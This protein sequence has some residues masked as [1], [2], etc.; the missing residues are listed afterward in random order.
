MEGA[1]ELQGLAKVAVSVLAGESELSKHR[2]SESRAVQDLFSSAMIEWIGSVRVLGG[3]VN[4]TELA[5]HGRHTSA[6]ETF[7]ASGK[8]PSP[9]VVLRRQGTCLSGGGSLPLSLPE[10]TPGLA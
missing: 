3:Q 6:E 9:D 4:G 2:G 8:K 10:P 7:S 1:R 5:A